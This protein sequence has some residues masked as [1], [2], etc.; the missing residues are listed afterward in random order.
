[1]QVCNGLVSEFKAKFNTNEINIIDLGKVNKLKGEYRDNKGALALLNKILFCY[2]DIRVHLEKIKKRAE[3]VARDKFGINWTIPLRSIAID[4]VRRPPILSAEYDNNN[5]MIIISSEARDIEGFAVH[6]FG[7]AIQD[8]PEFRALETELNKLTLSNS[9]AKIAVT[10]LNELRNIDLLRKEFVNITTPKDAIEFLQKSRDPLFEMEEGLLELRQ[11]GSAAGAGIFA[12]AISCQVTQMDSNVIR[13][14][15]IKN[16]LI[17][18]NIVARLMSDRIHSKSIKSLFKRYRLKLE[19]HEKEIS[20]L[21]GEIDK[22]RFNLQEMLS[23]TY[24]LKSGMISSADA[25][26]IIMQFQKDLP[27]LAA[28]AIKVEG[29]IDKIAYNLKKL[30]SSIESILLSNKEV[31]AP[32]KNLLEEINSVLN[33]VVAYE[34]EFRRKDIMELYNRSENLKENIYLVEGSSLATLIAEGF[35]V[36]FAFVY[37]GSYYEYDTAW[38]RMNS[39]TEYYASAKVALN[40]L[41]RDPKILINL[42]KYGSIPAMINFTKGFVKKYNIKLAKETLRM[43]KLSDVS[44]SSIDSLIR[45]FKKIQIAA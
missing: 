26:K 17:S 37:I 5:H 38:K 32:L 19:T 12:M 8:T 9:V 31:S 30:I 1:M 18:A 15:G 35:A 4:F 3:F 13:L 25:V 16:S 21:T 11:S 39:I 27:F 43:K 14:S 40:S 29:R 22:F 2:N 10:R 7:H 36:V 44:L 28:L 45:I 33:E 6:E 34:Y 24:R 42:F 23:L 41:K 20:D